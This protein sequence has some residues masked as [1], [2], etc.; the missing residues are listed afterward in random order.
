MERD[1][2]LV[3]FGA[4]G[5]TG[6]LTAAYLAGHVPAGTRWALA[7]RNR[8]KL[9]GLRERLAAQAPGSPLPDLLVADADDPGSLRALAASAR[10]VAGTVG[11]YSERGGPLVAACAAE[12]TD[13]LDL[14]GEPE[15]VDRMYLEHH[16][17]AVGSGARLVHACGF[18]SVP[19]DLG[20][21]FTVQQLPEG[22][23]LH[24]EGF[25]RARGT[26]S[27][28]T[29]HSLMG[30]FAEPGR[31]LAAGRA[32]RAAEPRP[33]GRRVRVDRRGVPRTRLARGWTLPLPSLDPQVVVRSAAAS[34]R[35][36]P[37]FTYGHYA[38][39]LHPTSAA[40][41]LV[42]AGGLL[43][44]AQVPALRE[45]LLAL[46]APGEG[47]TPEQ[48]AEGWFTVHFAGRGGGRRVYT[49]VSGP[50]PGYAGTAVMLAESALCLLH[51]DLPET[52][53]QVTPATAMGDAL[54][55]RL[56]AA[57][58]GFEVLGTAAD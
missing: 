36:G 19:H 8:D 54:I 25:V 5:Y 48:L 21:R 7:G 46:R 58:F 6:A 33:A 40:A 41:A 14:C 26:A 9:A 4:T 45:R 15:F 35:Y 2:D 44:A 27:G 38:A 51:D 55:G 49:R 29:L 53:G 32:R 16:A 23:P 43:A 3:L 47:P 52:S 20:A 37:D 57:G 10:V 34:E 50:E 28:G 56:R 42:G 12:G 22:V 31:T 13:Y 24:V 18:D 30:A 39:F 1:H 17:T 11:P